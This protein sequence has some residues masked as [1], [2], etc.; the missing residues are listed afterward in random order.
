ME[1]VAGL[2]ELMRNCAVSWLARAE[3]HKPSLKPVGWQDLQ[4]KPC[5][6]FAG[7]CTSCCFARL[8]H[9]PLL[10]VLHPGNADNQDVLTITLRASLKDELFTLRLA[11]VFLDIKVP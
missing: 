7:E 3:P 6:R 10:I 11:N 9:F 1:R 8:F 4:C 2:C 5:I